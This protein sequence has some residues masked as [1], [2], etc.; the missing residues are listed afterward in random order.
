MPGMIKAVGLSKSQGNEIDN[1]FRK[2]T[3]LAGIFFFYS[4]FEIFYIRVTLLFSRIFPSEKEKKAINQMW[5]QEHNRT[6]LQGPGGQQTGK[7]PKTLGLQVTGCCLIPTL[8]KTR[9]LD[10]RPAECWLL[11]PTGCGIC[12]H[13][14][15]ASQR[16]WGASSMRCDIYN[17]R[18]NFH[19]PNPHPAQG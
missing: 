2:T 4:L 6:Q 7:N 1:E 16:G 8:D 17:S 5:K 12:R 18:W 19:V 10:P 15:L 13:S 14:L 9:A 3:Q 11:F